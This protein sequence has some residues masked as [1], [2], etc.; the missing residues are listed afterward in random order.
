MNERSPLGHAPEARPAINGRGLEWECTGL[1][2]RRAFQYPLPPL[3]T[4]GMRISRETLINAARMAGKKQKP[5]RESNKCW[6]DVEKWEPASWWGPPAAP[7]QVRGRTG[8]STPGFVPEKRERGLRH[9][10]TSSE[11]RCPDR[12]PA[13]YGG[14]RRGAGG[15]EKEGHCPGRHGQ[16]RKGVRPHERDRA[17]QGDGCMTRGCTHCHFKM[18]G[19]ML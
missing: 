2:S 5:K 6:Q 1:R 11:W 13:D 8:H 7:Q 19:F 9:W 18:A 16:P 12:A 4:T 10:C 17:V 3:V 15:C 14:P